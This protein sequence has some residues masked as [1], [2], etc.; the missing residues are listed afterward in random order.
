MPLPSPQRG[1]VINYRF[2]WKDENDSGQVEGLKARPCLIVSINETT[3]EKVVRVVPIS[4]RNPGLSRNFL[5]ITTAWSIQGLSRYPS[6]LILDEINE[7]V[8]PGYDIE[9]LS[10]RSS[11]LYGRVTRGEFTKVL[12]TLKT[13]T[14]NIVVRS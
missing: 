9:P 2:L 5:E 1:S 11:S 3:N 7:F 14:E 10:H 4:T 13:L 12:E 8:W 6:Y